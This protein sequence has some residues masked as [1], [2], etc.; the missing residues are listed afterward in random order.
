MTTPKAFSIITP[1]GNPDSMKIITE[2]SWNGEVVYCSRERYLTARNE[3]RY[4]QQLER[5]GVY[6]LIGASD[7]SP[8]PKIYIGEGDPII[9]RLSQHGL[10]KDFWDALIYVISLNNTLDKVQIQY[11]ESKLVSL[12]KLAKTTILENGNAPQQPSLN[13]VSETNATNSLTNVMDCIRMLGFNFFEIAKTSVKKLETTKQTVVLGLDG[14]FTF[15]GNVRKQSIRAFG[16]YENGKF[17]VQKGSQCTIDLSPDCP[18]GVELMRKELKK[19]GVLESH[20]EGNALTFAQDYSFNS[21]SA[22]SGFI[23]GRASN[24]K[25]EWKSAEGKPLADYLK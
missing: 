9:N 1:D 20:A 12:A 6:I 16:T 19:N 14:L 10:K 8:L 13:L 11:I 5:P 15:T 18:K 24:G 21:P 3:P 2:G 23:A 4:K 17:T 22:A 25:Q 7:D